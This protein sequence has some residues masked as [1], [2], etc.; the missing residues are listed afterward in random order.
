MALQQVNESDEDEYHSLGSRHEVE[1]ETGGDDDGDNDEVDSLMEP[2]VHPV[3]AMQHAFEESILESS[4]KHDA[5]QESGDAET[6]RQRLL[7]AQKYDDAWTTR[8][9]Q[10]PSAQHH[11]LL[12]LMAQIVFGMHLLQQHQAK[13]PPEVVKILQTHVNEVDT[14]LERTADDFALA[15]TDTRDRIHHLQLPLAHLAVFTTMLAAKPFRTQLLAGNDNIEKIIDRTARALTAALTDVHHGVLATHQLATYLSAIKDR[16]PRQHPDIAAV[17]AAM[18]AN[19]HGW[20]QYL[21]DLQ[22]QGAT[23]AAALVSLGTLIAE[24]SRLAAAASRRLGP[25]SRPISPET[26]EAAPSPG[27]RSKFSRDSAGRVSALNKPL[28]MEPGAVAVGGAARDSRDSTVARRHPVPFAQRYESPRASPRMPAAVQNN[29][30]NDN[31]N[32]TDSNDNNTTPTP[33]TRRVSSAPATITSPS[34]PQRP[35][36]AG[37][38]REAPYSRNGDGTAELALFLKSSGPAGGGGG[39]GVSALSALSPSSLSPLPRGEVG[40]ERGVGFVRPGSRGGVL[41]KERGQDQEREQQQQQQRAHVPLVARAKSR[42][43]AVVLTGRASGVVQQQGGGAGGKGGAAAVVDVVLSRPG[44]RGT[45]GGGEGSVKAVS[46]GGGAGSGG[47]RKGEGGG[48]RNGFTRRLSMRMR[49]IPPP[50]PPPPHPHPPTTATGDQEAGTQAATAKSSGLPQQQQQLLLQP[51]GPN[52]VTP[53]TD[54]IA[55]KP[56]SYIAPRRSA[57][58]VGAQ[59]QEQEQQQQQTTTT[60]TTPT[61]EPPP[62]TPIRSATTPTPT[63]TLLSPTLSR[64]PSNLA[65]FPSRASEP[66]T[67]TAATKSFSHS[68][69]RHIPHALPEVPAGM[70]GKGDKG[71]KGRK[72]RGRSMSL[73]RIGEFLRGGRRGVV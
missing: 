8:W 4:E 62:L 17:F 12:K 67:P 28:P 32:T 70:G 60:P 54:K 22:S 45:V 71:D 63:P 11:P 35:R 40:G 69:G 27:L 30:D 56:V 59:L 72:A 13:S 61:P 14:F 20:R 49:H 58:M 5:A 64:P 37:A 24:M 21:A 16:W 1:V 38:A 18:R 10:H 36:T 26:H 47:L 33:R 7:E 15:I 51:N 73:M 46:L 3:T 19:E 50:P 34:P 55:R 2:P 42:G 29:D 44:S 66:L 68:N 43:T 39:G 6:R 65:L 48:V 41:T 57:M 9:K 53:R 52:G 31:N 25:L 23:L